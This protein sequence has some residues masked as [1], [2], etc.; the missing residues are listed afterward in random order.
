MKTAAIDRTLWLVRHGESTWND[1]G[2]IQG[3][4][5]G[6][7]LTER[8]RAQSRD[9]ADA[10]R[11]AAVAAIYA[12][13]LERAQQTAAFVGSTLGLPIHS[14]RALRERCFGVFEGCPSHALGSVQSGIRDER[15]TDATAR[16]ES[17]SMI[18]TNGR[19]CSWT[20]WGI[21]LTRATW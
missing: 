10:L 5:E 15:V 12:S 21:S 9:A 17:R 3:H 6:P 14:E 2:L 4:A 13:D 7:V 8:G 11:A 18:S 1:L 16:A 19:P 20:G